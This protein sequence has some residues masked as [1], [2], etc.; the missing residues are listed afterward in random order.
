MAESVHNRILE[1]EITLLYLI[2]NVLVEPHKDKFRVDLEGPDYTRKHLN[3]PGI[4]KDY[5]RVS[6][7]YAKSIAE[8]PFYFKRHFVHFLVAVRNSFI[9]NFHKRQVGI[10]EEAV[11]W[12][13]FHR[14]DQ[15]SSASILTK[16]ASFRLWLD[17]L[18]HKGNLATVLI[19]NSALHILSIVYRF[20]FNARSSNFLTMNGQIYVNTHILLFKT[21]IADFQ[22]VEQFLN[23][24]HNKFTVLRVSPLSFCDNFKHRH[25]TAV[26][27]ESPPAVRS[28]NG[29]SRILLHLHTLNQNVIHLVAT[30]K[31]E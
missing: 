28:L 25:A 16:V 24:T 11:I 22:L 9:R 15:F 1:V 4:L 29:F 21:G 5:F 6:H 8:T 2:A 30:V 7:I 27:V 20:N 3:R 26:I 10:L 13:F 12:V 18:F 17:A 19:L 23:F 14:A 31:K